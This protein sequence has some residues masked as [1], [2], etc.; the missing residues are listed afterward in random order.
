MHM[1]LLASVL[2]SGMNKGEEKVSEPTERT[3]TESAEL[4]H[5]S[6]QPAIAALIEVRLRLEERVL[7]VKALINFLDNAE[8]KTGS[9]EEALI[10][11]LVTNYRRNP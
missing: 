2:V 1:K 11:D 8:L 7:K 3:A 6:R 10:W 9:E 4:Y 5:G